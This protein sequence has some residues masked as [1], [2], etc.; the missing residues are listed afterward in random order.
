[1]SVSKDAMQRNSGNDQ[2]EVR[3]R[4]VNASPRAKSKAA[5]TRVG[6]LVDWRGAGNGKAK[7]GRTNQLRDGS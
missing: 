6:V 7:A 1:M 3:E 5:G 4:K 2:A